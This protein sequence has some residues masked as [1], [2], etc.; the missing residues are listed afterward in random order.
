MNDKYYSILMKLAKKATKH[1]DVPVSALIVK[2]NKIIA[3]AFNTKEKTNNVCNH[4]EVLVISKA[5]RK[6]K[7]WR[8]NDCDLY[9][10]LKPCSICENIIKQS[11]IQNVYYLLSKPNNK[12]EYNKTKFVET[13]NSMQ[14]EEYSQYL[15]DFFKLRRDKR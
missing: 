3:K 14:K 8:L 12:K 4:A 13:N 6:L 15:S 2:N 7:D 5:S 11:R 10:T 9:V 1:Q